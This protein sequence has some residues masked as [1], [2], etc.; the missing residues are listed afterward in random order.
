MKK[1][2]HDLKS[3]DVKRLML[4]S[5]KKEKGYNSLILYFILY[6]SLLLKSQSVIQFVI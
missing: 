2:V 5:I 4:V 6:T 1:H 3:M